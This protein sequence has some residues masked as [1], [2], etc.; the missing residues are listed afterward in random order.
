M[1]IG[2]IYDSLKRID[3]LENEIEELRKILLEDDDFNGEVTRKVSQNEYLI[4][5]ERS[6]STEEEYEQ[7]M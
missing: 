5:I 2:E 6:K 4:A 1:T 3:N 7:D